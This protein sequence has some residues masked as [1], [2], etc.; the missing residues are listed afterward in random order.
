[1]KGNLELNLARLREIDD[2][3]KDT[4]AELD[5]ATS[6]G[7][8]QEIKKRLQDL[9]IE[10][11]DRLEMSSANQKELRSQI[12]LIKE[13]FAR[14]FGRDETLAEKIRTLFREQGVTVVS[15][16][17]AVALAISTIASS[18][19]AAVRGPA[20]APTPPPPSKGGLTDW[21]KQRLKNFAEVL[22]KIGSKR[23][24]CVT[25]YYRKYLK[26][27]FKPFE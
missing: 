10:R 9:K 1:M 4:Q 25:G 15:I 5:E 18:V 8:R 23:R 24:G 16:L 13:T 14:M 7:E 20:P 12:S 21:I 17:A 22:K 6:D 27:D 26:L 11:F 2:K 3:I 19:V